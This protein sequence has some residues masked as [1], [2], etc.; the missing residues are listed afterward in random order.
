MPMDMGNEKQED[1]SWQQVLQ[2]CQSGDP[3]AFAQIAQI[4]QS[5]IANQQKEEGAMQG[6]GRQMGE[7][8]FAEKMIAAQEQPQG[9]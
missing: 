2:L 6:S 7:P 1:Q 8:S 4:A 9:E 5:Q 3:K